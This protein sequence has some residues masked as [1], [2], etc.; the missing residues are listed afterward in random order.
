MKFEESA[1]VP[2]KYNVTNIYTVLFVS[3]ILSTNQHVLICDI[4]INDCNTQGAQYLVW[5]SWIKTM[6]IWGTFY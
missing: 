5:L 6:K 1:L 2:Y 3:S 4:A